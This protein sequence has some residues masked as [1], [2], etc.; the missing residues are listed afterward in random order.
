MKFKWITAI[1]VT[2]MAITSCSEDTESIGASLTDET[3]LLEYSAGF[4]YANTQ[5]IK[6]DSVYAR[7]FDCYF[8]MVK[9]PE[10]G[11]YVVSEFMAQFNILENMVQPERSKIVGQYDG[12][13]AADSC[14]IWLMF[15]RSKC[16]GDSLTPLKVCIRELDR[17]MSDT[18]NYYTNYDPDA[19]GY[20]REGGLEKTMAFSL[21][22]L[23][24]TDSI[25]NL[26]NYVNYANIALSDAYTDKNGKTYNNYGT[27]VLRN[28]YDHPEYFKNCYSFVNNVCPGFN[29]E[30]IDGLGVMAKVAEIDMMIYYRAYDG[31][32]IVNRSMFM[33]STPE[34]LQTSRIYNDTGALQ[35]LI[36]DKS[37]TYLK[38]PAGIFTEATLPVDDIELYHEN[39]SLLSVSM[40]F[41]RIN[42][43]RYDIQY[44]LEAPAAVLMVHKDSLNTFFETQT[45]HN[46]NSTFLATLTSNAYSFTNIGNLITLMA[47]KKAEGLKN[48]P[49]WVANHP[50]W[51]KVVLVPVAAN[52]SSDS[53]GNRTVTSVGNEMGL[54]STRLI[55]GDGN[56][57]ELEVIFARFKKEE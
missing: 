20:I 22:N 6:V 43:G 49:N 47:N 21:A 27:Y 48:D 25:R 45:L 26:S 14:E 16:Y 44:P 17:P 42:S 40:S 19:E 31:D 53:Y 30:V 56:P 51:N 29:F 54:S 8:G 35:H 24:D 10:T 28:F 57:I 5:S 34:V 37:C 4:F 12:D 36:D 50:N 55:G 23:T 13:I 32:S 52:Y 18:R 15:D 11:S 1:A 39:D 38:A 9:D 46:Y 2:A 3:D 41:N 7:N 33:S